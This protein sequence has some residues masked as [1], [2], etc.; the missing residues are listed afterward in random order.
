MTESRCPAIKD[1]AGDSDDVHQ[2]ART[3]VGCE[4]AL[5]AAVTVVTAIAT[6]SSSRARKRGR[7]VLEGHRVQRHESAH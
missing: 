2:P 3:S 7:L 4:E 1:D 5:H 6:R